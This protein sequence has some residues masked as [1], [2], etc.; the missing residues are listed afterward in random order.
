MRHGGFIHKKS[1]TPDVVTVLETQVDDMPGEALGYLMERLL[2]AGALDVFYIP[3]YMKKNRPGTLVTVLCTPERQGDITALLFAESTTLGVRVRQTQRVV[4][5]R[6]FDSVTVHG[7]TIR[8][9]V[10][11]LPQGERRMPEYEDCKRAALACGL[12]LADI[13]DAARIQ[14]CETECGV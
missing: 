8:V 6:R 12:P 4:L 11:I 9:K 2:E 14:P 3:V 5:P 1:L 10:A 7:Q 13:M